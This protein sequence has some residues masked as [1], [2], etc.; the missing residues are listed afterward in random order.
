[1][2]KNDIIQLVEKEFPFVSKPK[3]N[4]IPFHSDECAHCIFTLEELDKYQ[5]EKLP[6]EAIRYLYDEMSTLSSI[7]WSWVLPSYLRVA[8]SSDDKYDTVIEFLI[9]NLSPA[10]EF[11]KETNERL[12]FLSKGQVDCI[13]ELLKFW[14]CHEHWGS[15][16]RAELE[17]AIEYIGSKA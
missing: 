9:Y 4:D 14:L 11:V 15:F 1:M 10:D 2:N 13:V 8:L 6:K 7:G 5:G 17:R 3:R 16:C 12:A